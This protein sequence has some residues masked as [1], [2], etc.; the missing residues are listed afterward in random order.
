MAKAMIGLYEN[1]I[2]AQR[3]IYDLYHAGI[4]RDFVVLLSDTW[5]ESHLSGFQQNWIAKH[6]DEYKKHVEQGGA[7]VIAWV[8]NTFRKDAKSVF[9]A[10]PTQSFE[11]VRGRRWVGTN[12][13]RT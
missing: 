4:Q 11:E 10:H 9:E 8:I 12:S 6:H 5:D 7:I 3:V 13:T 1:R 2:E